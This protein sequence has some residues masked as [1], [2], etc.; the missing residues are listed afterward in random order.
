MK[1]KADLFPYPVL[2]TVTD[3]YIKSSFYAELKRGPVLPTQ[4]TLEVTFSL[5]DDG[6]EKLI[7]NGRA[8]YAVHIEGIASS[9]RK[10]YTT[11]KHEN[12]V[13]IRL[14]PSEVGDSLELNMMVIAV[15]KI[16]SYRNHNFNPE[17]YDPDYKITSMDKGDILAFS[18]YKKLR[19][20]LENENKHDAKSMMKVSGTKNKYMSVDLD[21]DV[22]YIRLPELAYEKY[23]VLSERSKG[24]EK[25]LMITT[26][27][28]ALSHVINKIQHGD[29]SEESKWYVSLCDILK[30]LNYNNETL[31][32]EDPMQIAQKILNNPLD[33][34]FE[35]FFK[36]RDTF[37]ESAN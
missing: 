4:M 15:K 30:K 1:L 22:I 36:E 34:A 37:D 13:T 21:G 12:K 35:A 33:D 9:Y 32:Q 6:I 5:N 11:G 14:K 28:P 19:I 3:D 10:L 29:V 17:F 8:A 25:L 2:S 23:K 26:V 24:N 16:N 7:E 31:K 20:G 27:L 18:P